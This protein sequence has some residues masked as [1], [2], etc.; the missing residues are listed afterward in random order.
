MAKPAKEKSV[1]ILVSALPGSLAAA[2]SILKAHGMKVDSVLDSIGVITGEIAEKK[3]SG[4]KKI[5]G[6]KVEHDQTVQLP[7]PDAPVQ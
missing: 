1:R 6:I 2:A 4:L 5:S 3:L 7:P